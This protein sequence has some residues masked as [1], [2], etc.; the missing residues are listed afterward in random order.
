MSIEQPAGFFSGGTASDLQRLPLYTV[1]SGMS[2]TVYE[3]F[4]LVAF[5]KALVK[6]KKTKLFFDK[7][8]KWLFIYLILLLVFSFLLGMNEEGIVRTFRILI[9][10]T[11]FISLPYLLKSMTEMLQFCYLLFPFI[12]LVFAG[13]IYEL[14]N[15]VPIIGLIKSVEPDKV[16]YSLKEIENISSVAR[17]ISA[18]F[19]NLFCFISSLFIINSKINISLHKFYLYVV[20]TIC[21]LSVLLSATRGW[22]LAYTI[23]AFLFF[24]TSSVNPGRIATRILVPLLIF[25]TLYSFIPVFK[26]QINNAMV[27]IGTLEGL[28]HGDV[29]LSSTQTRTTVRSAKVMEAFYKNPITGWGFSSKG[30]HDGHVGN[31]NLLQSTGVIGYSLFLYFWVFYSTKLIRVKQRLSRGNPFKLSLLILVFGLVGIFIVH[32]TSTQ[33]FGYDP[34]FSAQNKIFFLVVFFVFSDVLLKEAIYV[35]IQDINI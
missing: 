13:Q 9:F 15:G 32:S 3:I 16:G 19:L 25:F 29:T 31:Q 10:W 22:F 14:I 34:Q 4:I 26:I 18:P 23:T 27:R 2:F 11:L 21:Y 33:M 8:L 17:F 35:D 12:F 6:G 30:A 24:I 7:P 5:L 28:I 20:A 1:A